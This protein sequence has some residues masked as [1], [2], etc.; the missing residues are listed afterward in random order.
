MSA[1][2]RRWV[3]GTSRLGLVARGIVL[4]LIGG[5]VVEAALT[6]DPNQAR[7]LEG[8]LEM[9]LTNPW[10]MGAIGIGLVAYAIYQL[11]KARYRLV[12]LP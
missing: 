1:A 9:F 2:Q 3:L 10:L 11:V 7:G 8:V 5:S 6:H 4:A 12:G